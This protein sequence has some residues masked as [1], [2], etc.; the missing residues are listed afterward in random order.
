[1]SG[2]S[3][4]R[5]RATAAVTLAALF[6]LP[7]PVAAHQL[8]GR[9]ESPLPL[10]VYLG[11]AAFAVAL[12]FALV[13]SRP[14]A[15]AR[16]AIGPHRTVVVPVWLRGLLR[17][18][19]FVAWILVVGQVVGGGSG[20]AD[21]A[22]LVLWV[23]GWVGLAIV[24][25]LIGPAWHWLDPFTTLHDAGAAILRRLGS[26]GW[27]TT[28]YPARLGRW[29]AV[30]GLL[31]FIWLELAVQQAGGGTTLGVILIGY[32]AIALLCMALFG[33]DTWRANG[34]VFS[35]WFAT[36][37][38]MAPLGPVPDATGHPDGTLEVRRLG[39][40]LRVADWHVDRLV[41]VALA[42]GAVIFDGL[43][44]TQP[45][46]DVFG[47]Q[48]FAGLTIQLVL[49]LALIVVAVLG[50]SRIVGIA[51]LGAGLVPVAAG[52]IVAHYLTYLLVDGQR[53]IIVLSDPFALGWDIF[54]TAGFEAS[55][56]WLPPVV[57]WIAQVV[58]VV[59][60]HV[61]GAVAG[62]DVAVSE[63]LAEGGDHATAIRRARRRQVP[64]AILMVAL[65]TLTL[66]SLGQNLVEGDTEQ[67]EHSSPTQLAWIEPAAREPSSLVGDVAGT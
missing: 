43:S 58:A 49:F 24:S 20:A 6:G 45:W 65:T 9:Y 54:G 14:V 57:V 2:S 60:G 40:G 4:R 36:L 62:H 7:G 46:Y 21:P 32:T 3:S 29:P 39:A 50:T 38:R 23:Y 34:E 27:Q 66:W 15:P 16:E 33:R 5:R 1:V 59:G 12:S 41:L 31:A 30:V 44:Q 55:G 51:A 52:Y 63:A 53:I 61:I 35:V 22:S 42:I 10:V 25:S 26:T 8:V 47:Q 28:A 37:G 64:L 67:S 56:D 11:A 48:A 19:G 18:V 17:I 13:L